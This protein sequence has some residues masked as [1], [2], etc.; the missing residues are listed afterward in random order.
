MAIATQCGDTVE[1]GRVCGLLLLG[2]CRGRAMG[3]G[4]PW[5]AIGTNGREG[6]I[7]SL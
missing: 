6:L 2:T 5:R 4:I 1:E 7:L 3:V